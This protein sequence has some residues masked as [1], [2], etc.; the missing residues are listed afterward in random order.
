MSLWR[1]MNSDVLASGAPTP[2]QQYGD[3]FV[4]RDDLYEYAGVEGGKVRACKALSEK[5]TAGLVTAGSRSSPQVNI[6]AHIG[7]H[8]GLPTRGHVPSGDLTP[9][10]L[11]AQACGMEIVQ[12]RPG[13]N[14]V[15]V[16]RAE[17][18]AALRKWTLIPFSMA[19]LMPEP[20]NT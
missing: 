14:S 10:L 12:H 3:Y 15:I 17:D 1:L 20:G 7:R 9:E 4:K 13:H 8:L 11:D 5:A 2:V 16:K 18:D 19:G 6:V